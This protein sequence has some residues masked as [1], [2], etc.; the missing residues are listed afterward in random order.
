MQ[1]LKNYVID[2][3]GIIEIDN[4]FDVDSMNDEYKTIICELKKTCTGLEVVNSKLV[5]FQDNILK[6]EKYAEELLSNSDDMYLLFL[7]FSSGQS[8]KRKR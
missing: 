2:Y 8:F 3:A 7:D 4:L 6:Y 5:E 1:N